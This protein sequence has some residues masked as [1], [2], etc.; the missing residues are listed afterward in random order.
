MYEYD[1]DMN[2]GTI[3]VIES[4]YCRY[5][6]KI[7]AYNLQYDDLR[8]SDKHAELLQGMICMVMLM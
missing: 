4:F 3:H 5:Q 8:D 1:P 2:E 6:R 7:S